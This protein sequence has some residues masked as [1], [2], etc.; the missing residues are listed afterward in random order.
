MSLERRRIIVLF[1]LALVALWP[2]G[3]RVLVDRYLVNPWEMG[4]FAMYV[5]PNRPIDVKLRT[6]AG[7]FVEHQQFGEAVNAAFQ[8][9]CHDA[10]TLGLLANAELL[11]FEL[12]RAGWA[13]EYV[14]VEVRR[15]MIA[16][17]GEMV[18]RVA[19]RQFVTQ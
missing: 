13:Y 12:R 15:S 14:D 10:Q 16:S 2:V 17:S 5:Q 3:H 7:E 6:P 1:V 18:V 4:G 8:T 9:Y 11:I 19:H